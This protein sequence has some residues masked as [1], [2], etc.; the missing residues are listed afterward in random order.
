MGENNS[1][2]ND[3]VLISKVY[4]HLTW[5]NVRKM[6][7]P[8]KKWPEELNRRFSTEDIQKANKHMKRCTTSLT[9]R[10]MEI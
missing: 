10:E 6:T 7:N 9:I 2:K 4:K 3:K 8:I 5:L 1:K